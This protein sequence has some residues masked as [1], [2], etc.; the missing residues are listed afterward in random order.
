MTRTLKCIECG[1]VVNVSDYGIKIKKNNRNIVFK[2]P[3]S[4]GDYKCGKCR[5]PKKEIKE[6]N[7][8][9]NSS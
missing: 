4:D 3:Y 2:G 6:L 8:V 7:N 5:L 1:K 9:R